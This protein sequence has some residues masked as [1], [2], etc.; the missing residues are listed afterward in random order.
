VRNLLQG[1]LAVSWMRDT[2]ERLRRM[3]AGELG[4]V[5]PDG[6]APVP[7]FGRH[8]DPEHWDDLAR[9]FFLTD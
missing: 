2:V 3:P 1:N 5:M 7:G 6:G 4:V 8:L 9:E